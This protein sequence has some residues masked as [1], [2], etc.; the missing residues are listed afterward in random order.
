[1]RLI[2]TARGYGSSEERIG[3]H[4]G[5]RRDDV[6]VVTKLG[7]DVEGAEDWAAAAV[8]R[9]VERG[10]AHAACRHA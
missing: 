7:Y 6:V 10:A 5:A 4:L 1:V 9:G 2:D 8:T 3:R